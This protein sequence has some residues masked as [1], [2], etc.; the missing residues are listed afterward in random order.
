[1]PNLRPAQHNASCTVALGDIHPWSCMCKQT[2]K[3]EG[4][5]TDNL[6]IPRPGIYMAGGGK[7]GGDPQHCELSW[8]AGVPGIETEE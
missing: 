6:G 1:M 5:I 3:T 8:S 7:S 4:C 2:Q